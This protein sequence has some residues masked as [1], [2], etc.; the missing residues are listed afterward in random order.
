MM[1]IEIVSHL[2]RPLSLSVRLFGNIMGEDLVLAIVL[3]LVPFLV[4]MP[5]F[6]LMIFTSVIQTMVFV[7]LSM[8]YISMAMEEAH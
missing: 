7:I 3:I 6:I 8:M 1:P 2:S 4:P 5:L